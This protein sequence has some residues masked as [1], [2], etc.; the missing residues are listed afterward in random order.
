MVGLGVFPDEPG[1]PVDVQHVGGEPV[2]VGCV[3]PCF[4]QDL[5]DNLG[6]VGLATANEPADTLMASGAGANIH[7]DSGAK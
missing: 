6:A 5:A 2:G 7:A 1:L 3:D 4:A